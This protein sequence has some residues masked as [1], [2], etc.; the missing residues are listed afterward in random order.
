M[1]DPELKYCPKCKD[2]YMSHAANCAACQITLISGSDMQA[3]EQN[4]QTRRS[5]RAA[6]I[7]ADDDIVAIHH[8]GIGEIRRLEELLAAE[9]IAVLIVGDDQSCGGGCCPG[10]FYLNVLREDALDAIRI[11]DQEFDRTTG[12]SDHDISNAEAVFNPAALVAKC[13]A[14]GASFTPDGP[15]CPE[16]GLCF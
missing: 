10:S 3:I 15:E 12:F 14:C 5:E 7:S 2:E 13:P 11:I 8:A 4:I 1:F 6:T 9:N 16:C